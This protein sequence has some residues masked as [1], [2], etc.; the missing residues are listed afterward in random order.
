MTNSPLRHTE[1]AEARLTAGQKYGD[2]SL[3]RTKTLRR[4]QGDGKVLAD[5][6]KDRRLFGDPLPQAGRVT[7]KHGFSSDILFIC[8]LFSLLSASSFQ[9]LFFG[10]PATHR[11]VCGTI[12]V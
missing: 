4:A 7:K 11:A 8:F 3:R 12:L 5:A 1:P 9:L 10:F 2:H 6:S